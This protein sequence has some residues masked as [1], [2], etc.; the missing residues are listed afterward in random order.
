MGTG[1]RKNR[2]NKK[3]T[4]FEPSG[5]LP[6]S[7]LVAHSLYS[8]TRTSPALYQKSSYLIYPAVV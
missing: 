1:R 7:Q 2:A 5:V 4:S 8:F 6:C 3:A